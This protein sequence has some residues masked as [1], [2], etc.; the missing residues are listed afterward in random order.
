VA[1][2]EVTVA[3]RLEIEFTISPLGEVT[4]ET[5]GLKGEDC[6]EETK[7]LEARLGEVRRRTKTGEFWQRAAGTSGTVKRGR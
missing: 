2:L 6:L 3:E 5:H 1:A 4:L 7:A